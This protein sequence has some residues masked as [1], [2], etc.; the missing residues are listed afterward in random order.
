[1]DLWERCLHVVLVG[2]TEEEGSGREGR[3]TRGGEEEDKALLFK[4]Y[5][6][7][8]SGK[9]CQDIYQVTIREK[10]GGVF[11]PGGSLH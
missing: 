1:M 5:S 2:G 9:L 7:V 10:G 6:K 8:M 4:F 11:P 3:S